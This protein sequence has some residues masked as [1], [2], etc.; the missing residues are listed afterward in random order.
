MQENRQLAQLPLGRDPL[1]PQVLLHLQEHDASTSNALTMKPL[2]PYFM[3][4]KVSDQ[5][6]V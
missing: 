3:Y 1:L 4:E 2:L 5:G 6:P